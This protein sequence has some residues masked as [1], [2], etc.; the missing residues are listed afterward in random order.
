MADQ[1]MMYDP[2]KV[3]AANQSLAT[4]QD[5]FVRY[6]FPAGETAPGA[7]IAP[8]A[9]TP[10][11]P[12]SVMPVIPKAEEVSRAPSESVYD[13]AV[14]RMTPVSMPIEDATPAQVQSELAQNIQGALSQKDAA[15]KSLYAADAAMSAFEKNQMMRDRDRESALMQVQKKMEDIDKEVKDFKFDNRSIWE[16][17][18]TG[19]KVALAISGF[20]SSLSPQSAKAFQD[21][22][23]NI[24]DRDL[25]Q[26]KLQYAGLKEKGKELQSFYGQLVSRFGDERTADLMIQRIKL[27]N[28]KDKAKMMADN[29][30]SKIVAANAMK[31]IELTDAQI[32]KYNAEIFKL[33]AEAQPKVIGNKFVGKIKDESQQRE[34]TTKRIATNTAID[35]ID[36]LKNM[37][38][39]A[40]LPFSKESSKFTA[41]KEKLAAEIAK[42]NAG[43]KPSDVEIENA[44][45]MIPSVYS[46][47]FVPT[48][49]ALQKRLNQ[50]LNISAKQYGLKVIGEDIGANK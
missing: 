20:L 11:T 41:L 42:A 26:Q 36:E 50:D 1:S 30:Q 45:A 29:A 16:K 27:E 7:A 2:S 19:Q 49:E 4:P 47:N 31:A 43:G 21:N 25:E 32:A 33:T 17:A 14:H 13:Q 40:R 3:A 9:S 38:S 22:I 18:S 48:M 44:K 6:I 24:M 23:S 34:F 15:D 8:K 28:I 35:S 10:I 46:P 39:G 12:E 5:D 37:A